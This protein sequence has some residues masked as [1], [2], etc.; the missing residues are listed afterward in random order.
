MSPQTQFYNILYK[1]FQRNQVKP[2]SSQAQT[3]V[4]PPQRNSSHIVKK[5]AEFINMTP[6]K[7]LH[8]L[9]S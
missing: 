9:D 5:I 1:N 7:S 8:T 3:K 6:F 4:G 2:L